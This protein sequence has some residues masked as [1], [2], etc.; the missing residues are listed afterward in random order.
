MTMF[1]K[2]RGKSITML[3]L[4]RRYNRADAARARAWN[5]YAATRETDERLYFRFTKT[6]ALCD[7]CAH[8]I[9]CHIQA[10]N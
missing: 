10:G 9:K 4:S 6:V 2:K 3:E 5:A 7:Y 1:I 8:R